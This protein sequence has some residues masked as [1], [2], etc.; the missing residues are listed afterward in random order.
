MQK[1]KQFVKKQ[2]GLFIRALIDW[3][4]ISRFDRF[5]IPA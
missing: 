5:Q 1:F 3:P 2:E 4:L